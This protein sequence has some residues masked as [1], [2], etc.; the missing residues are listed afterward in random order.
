MA[1]LIGVANA[2]FHRFYC[3]STMWKRGLN[4]LIT[5][6]VP[7]VL[8][9]ATLL[10]RSAALSTVHQGRYDYSIHDGEEFF[11]VD[12]VER[13]DTSAPN[14][15]QRFSVEFNPATPRPPLH[16]PSLATL[17]TAE[18]R[19][20]AAASTQSMERAAE[21]FPP[22][23]VSSILAAVASGLW[24]VAP[25]LYLHCVNQQ[26]LSF[27]PVLLLISALEVAMMVVS[28]CR[29]DDSQAIVAS[30][31]ALRVSAAYLSSLPLDLPFEALEGLI[32]FGS[33]SLAFDAFTT[34]EETQPANHKYAQKTKRRPPTNF[35]RGI[36]W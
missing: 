14:H 12:K 20:A 34:A 11:F 4:S 33:A 1:P 19:L 16:P 21:E 29:F 9:L 10:L 32:L 28:L 7:L 24:T 18:S 35:Q 23:D 2:S 5:T 27:L 3:N 8:V 22:T 26:M 13:H 25:V 15:R 6:R 36:Q 31:V 30:F 17:D